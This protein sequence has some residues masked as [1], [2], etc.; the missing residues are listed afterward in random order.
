[1]WSSSKRRAPFH[2][3]S[4]IVALLFQQTSSQHLVSDLFE[5]TELFS[6]RQLCRACRMKHKS[7]QRSA[8]VLKYMSTVLPLV[9]GKSLVG[10]VLLATLESTRFEVNLA[11]RRGDIVLHVNP[12]VGDRQLVLNSAPGGNWGQ[13]ERKPVRLANGEPFT[14]I[15]MVTEQGFKVRSQSRERT[16]EESFRT[17]RSPSTTNTPLTSTIACHSMSLTPSRLRVMLA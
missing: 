13:E 3:I 9:I 5:T 1:M 14:L 2:R 8:T 16:F 11:N 7:H 17:N 15:I 12:R 6:T 4:L 10:W